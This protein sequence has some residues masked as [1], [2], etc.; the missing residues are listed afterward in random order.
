LQQTGYQE[1]IPQPAPG[2]TG[3]FQAIG[4]SD[5]S[6]DRFFPDLSPG[7]T[8]Q[9][10]ASATSGDSAFLSFGS[11]FHGAS[12]NAPKP[13]TAT[14]RA[15]ELMGENEHLRIE[16]QSLQATVER[17]KRDLKM[18]EAE[19]DQA[20]SE[21]TGLE[22]QAFA[23][24]RDN[25]RWQTKFQDLTN[26]FQHSRAEQAGRIRQLTQM[27][28]QLQNLIESNAPAATIDESPI[29]TS[30]TPSPSPAPSSSDSSAALPPVTP[31]TSTGEDSPPTTDPIDPPFDTAV[32][33]NE[34]TDPPIVREIRIEAPGSAEVSLG[35][36]TGDDQEID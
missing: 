2:A 1:E 9:S 25:Q 36:Q 15:L 28:D 17:L 3:S 29:E 35:D 4:D 21:M 11:Q 19:L 34:P 7:T 33:A 22:Q 8:A 24:Q 23:L 26:Y 10:D 13:K 18:R 12:L 5:A 20:R 30:T 27:I 16:I 32:P 14:Q 31:G 6:P